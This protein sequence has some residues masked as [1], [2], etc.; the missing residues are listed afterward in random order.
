MALLDPFRGHLRPAF[1]PFSKRH[2]D[3]RALLDHTLEKEVRKDP[4]MTLDN[5]NDTLLTPKSDSVCPQSGFLTEE[6][7]Q[8]LV[9][10]VKNKHL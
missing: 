5:P 7:P 8:K 6:N 10:T 4:R 3:Y 1:D 2:T 9:R